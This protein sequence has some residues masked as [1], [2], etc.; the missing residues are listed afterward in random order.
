MANLT[1]RAAFYLCLARAFLPPQEAAAYEAIKLH[2][3]DDL[4]DLVTTLNYPAADHLGN[5]CQAVARVSDH[6]ALLQ[7]YSGLFLAPPVP[8]TLNAGR[9][10]DGAIMGRA[11]VAIAKCY[12]DA[13]LDCAGSCHDL[14]DHVSLQLEFVAYLC[15][16]EAAGGAPRIKADDFLASFVCHWLPPFIAA[17]EQACAQDEKAQIYLCLAGLLQVIVNHDLRN[18]VP[19]TMVQNTLNGGERSPAMPQNAAQ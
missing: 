8:V 15:A 1:D 13:G 10:L 17:L 6:L 19:G 14:P 3:A 2:L 11:T 9:Y 16:S 18:Q 4:S 5:L 7:V 12:R